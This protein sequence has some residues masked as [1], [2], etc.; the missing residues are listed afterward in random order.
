MR[1]EN[2]RRGSSAGSHMQ[3]RK[4]DSAR[5]KEPHRAHASANDENCSGKCSSR[6]GDVMH[7]VLKSISVVTARPMTQAMICAIFGC[8]RE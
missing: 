8:A 5:R 2:S 3:R 4:T 7:R 1:T 6:L